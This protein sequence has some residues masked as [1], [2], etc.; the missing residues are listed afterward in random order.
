LV[1]VPQMSARPGSSLNVFI[2]SRQIE[3]CAASVAG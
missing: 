1:H 2:L 3:I